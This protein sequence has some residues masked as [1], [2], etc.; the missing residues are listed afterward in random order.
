MTAKGWLKCA[1]LRL[2][3]HS[4]K[5]KTTE[6][7]LRL[8]ACACC[9]R[10]WDRITD[11][12]SRKAIQISE[13]Y[14][15]G[16]ATIKELESAFMAADRVHS[17]LASQWLSEFMSGD[18]VSFSL[19]SQA[20]SIESSAD[21]ARLAA[22]PEARGLADGTAIAAMIA[23]AG[24]G[25]DYFTHA[26]KEEADQCIL[27]RDIFGNPFHSVSVDPSWLTPTVKAMARRIYGGRAFERL[28]ELAQELEK[29]ECDNRQMLDHCHGPGPHVRGCWVVDLVL[30]KG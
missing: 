28:P 7:K 18:R 6:R 19:P 5:G 23:V 8:F 3:L 25:K 2:M 9:R 10:I 11:S 15:D 27:L 30:R 14:A 21:A 29:V 13:L 22:H 16:N 17:L 26:L 20:M 12:C 1:D 4:L 24:H